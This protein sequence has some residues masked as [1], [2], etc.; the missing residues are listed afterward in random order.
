[1]V[2]ERAF[3]IANFQIT[4]QELAKA[5]LATG[6]NP[7]KLTDLVAHR[8]KAI[9][10]E[11][12]SFALDYLSAW[13]ALAEKPSQSFD[14]AAQETVPKT[15]TAVARGYQFSALLLSAFGNDM[16]RSAAAAA[17]IRATQTMLAVERYR[18]KH[19]NTLPASLAQLVPELLAAVP[20]DPFDNQPLR[21]R[22][23]PTKGYVV[24]SVGK[25][26]KD[27]GGIAKSPDGKT[28]LDLVTMVGR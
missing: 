2:G 24:Y 13:V 9:F 26:R 17:G 16:I 5:W 27:D 4:D 14:P 3:T 21:F 28:E 20:P 19:A 18:L 23:L 22:K 7:G 25:D 8:K 12:F 15:D 6:G 10:Q 11:D 1:V